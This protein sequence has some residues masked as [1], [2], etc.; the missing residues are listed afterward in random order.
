MA[1]LATPQNA[2]TPSR[3]D[4][5]YYKAVLAGRRLPAAFIDVDLLD[6]NIADIAARVSNGKTVRVA[7]KSVRCA[8]ALRR[9]LDANP[10]FQG[11]MAY[12]P[13]EAAW[14]AEQGFDDILLGY[15]F[16][17][18]IEIETVCRQ[19]KLGKTIL[20]MVDHADH[21]AHIGEIAQREGVVAPLCIDVDMSSEFPAIYFGVKRSA[22]RT[23]E[24]IAPVIAA[25]Q[26]QPAVE[27]RGLMGYEA[28]IAGLGDRAPSGGISNMVIPRLK[29]RSIPEFRARRAAA[30]AAIRDAGIAL[31][32]VNGG[33]T[34]SVEST[35]QEAVVTEVTVGSGF[36]SPTL[37]DHYAQF[38]HLPAAAYAI[39]VVRRPQP[40]ML[41]C[42]GGG[43][44]ASGQ[45]GK[46]K[47][48]QPY[49]PEG[50]KLL[51]QE[52]AGEVQTPVLYDGPERLDLG[53]P[54]F[55]RH[56]KAGEICER[57]KSMLLI[58]DG[59]VIDEVPTYRG[60]GQCFL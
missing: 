52:G 21:V 43:Y 42:A 10:V 13:D 32:L 54:V 27:L 4:Y 25:V 23:P 22:L 57:F 36:F 55:L 56:A 20:F 41:T 53:D 38:H 51:D 49:L 18:D 46:N 59:R 7:T 8:W 1:T 26:A 33:G 12:H 24:Q 30:V 29:K 6:R 11:L 50:A 58:S 28:Q 19:L 15:P 14:L 31:P 16:Y 35:C 2:S 48:P 44:A 5:A 9:I 37:F 47:L 17:R 34:G 3:P 39:E 60:E 40:G 45:A